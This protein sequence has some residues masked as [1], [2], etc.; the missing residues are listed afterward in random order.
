M[1]C[2][3]VCE[4]PQEGAGLTEKAPRRWLWQT[5]GVRRVPERADFPHLRQM[6][7]WNLLYARSSAQY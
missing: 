4:G 5:G 2:L 1:W 6:F 3:W 7:F